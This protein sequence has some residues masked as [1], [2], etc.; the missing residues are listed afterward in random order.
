MGEKEITFAVSNRKSIQHLIKFT[1]NLLRTR[2]S[3]FHDN[4]P[5]YILTTD[6]FS[7]GN[8][9]GIK[10]MSIADFLLSTEW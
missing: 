4:Y 8:Y 3:E 6:E 2:L 7:G 5:K 10:A 1:I 9:E